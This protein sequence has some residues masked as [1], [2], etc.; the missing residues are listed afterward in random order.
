VSLDRLKEL[1]ADFA[2]GT[3]EGAERDEFRSLVSAA[4]EAHKAEA[5]AVVDAATVVGL[6]IPRA[7]A[8]ATLRARLL[9]RVKPPQETPNLFKFLHEEQQGAWIPLKIPGAYVKLLH[10]DDLQD[11]AVVL[12]KLDPGAKYPAHQHREGEQIY[13]LTGDLSIGDVKLKAGDFH[14]AGPGSAHGIN[15]SESGCTI[16]AVLS[17]K[18]LMAQ[19]A[20][21]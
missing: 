15:H 21:T 4:S 9:N 2:A 19:F 7:Q 17:K 18:D 3:L 8:P 11:Y 16:L 13:I 1:A 5:A 12:G 6:S 14:H 20:A 10:M